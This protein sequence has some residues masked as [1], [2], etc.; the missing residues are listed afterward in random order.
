MPWVFQGSHFP[1]YICLTSKLK[2]ASLTIWE[3]MSKTL[4]MH[5]VKIIFQNSLFGTSILHLKYFKA[6]SLIH[7]FCT[8]HYRNTLSHRGKGQ[9]LANKPLQ[10]W[11]PFHSLA[12]L[13]QFFH[14]KLLL[15]F[16]HVYKCILVVS[17]PA[18]CLQLLPDT[19][20]CP[21]FLSVSPESKI[22]AH[23]IHIGGSHP[24]D[25]S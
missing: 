17:S 1:F 11:T 6:T 9:L 4:Y 8:R 15:R 10:D 7:L 12:N 18:P 14:L 25:C 23:K 19:L 21:F 2:S 5:S 20:S 3:P 13:S 24:R 22:S 16:I